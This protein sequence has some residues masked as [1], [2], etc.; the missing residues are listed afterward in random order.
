MLWDYV[1]RKLKDHERA[2][3][4]AEQLFICATDYSS[5]QEKYSRLN[6]VIQSLLIG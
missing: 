6:I 1:F 4:L 3:T 2:L 5:F